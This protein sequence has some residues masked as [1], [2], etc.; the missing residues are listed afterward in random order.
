MSTRN[1]AERSVYNAWVAIPPRQHEPPLPRPRLRR[2]GR[3]EL[4]RMARALRAN[5]PL[6]A[7]FVLAGLLVAFSS[8]SAVVFTGAAGSA[9]FK[10][11][12]GT[13][14]PLGAGLE[15]LRRGSGHEPKATFTL[16]TH[17]TRT[18]A[19]A[20]AVGDSSSLGPVVSTLS[21][22][23]V[24][25]AR[26]AKSIEIVLMARTGATRHIRRLAGSG[27]GIWLADSVASYLGVGPGDT[28]AVHG[29]LADAPRPPRRV[30]VGAIYRALWKSEANDYWAN[31]SHEIYPPRKG[32]PDM[33]PTFAFLPAEQLV[34]LHTAIGGHT[35]DERWEVPVR[36][37]AMTLGRARSLVDRFGRIGEQLASPRS[38]LS[39]SLG[40]DLGPFSGVS[41]STTSSLR[42][43]VG[44]ADRN[45]SAVAGSSALLGGIGTVVALA[46]AAA[47][48]FFLVARRRGEM[49]YR[50]TRGEQTSVFALRTALE[51]LPAILLGGVAGFVAV[52]AVVR[53]FEPHASFD[54]ANL[55]SAALVAAAALLLAGALL[56]SAACVAFLRQFR[57][58]RRSRSLWRRAP[59]ELVPALA[60][61][62]LLVTLH[63]SRS[64]DRPTSVAAFALPLLL[65]AGLGGVLLRLARLVVARARPRALP[66]SLAVRR[67]ASGSSLAALLTVV[68]A[69]ASGVLFYG[70]AVR[71]SLAEGTRAKGLVAIGGDVQGTIGGDSRL[72]PLPFPSTKVTVAYGGITLGSATGDQA[73]LMLVEPGRLAGV[74]HWNTAWGAS[75]RQLLPRLD[76]PDGDGLAVI[77]A[78]TSAGKPLGDAWISGDRV[79]LRVVG[80]VRAFPSMSTDRPLLIASADAFDRLGPAA[81]ELST[82][83]FTYV[84]A[85]GDER[86][87]ERALAA[88]PIGADYLLTRHD[89]LGAR[90]VVAAK[91][92]YGF[93]LLLGAASGVLALVGLLLYLSARQRSQTLASALLRRMG[94][95]PAAELASLACEV[96]AILAL[97][98]LVGAVV[99]L[100]TVRLVI[101]SLDP[102]PQY[103]PAPDP[104][105]PWLALAVTPALVVV[106][107]LVA[108]GLVQRGSRRANVVEELRAG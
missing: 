74:V 95:R 79:P 67:V 44:L 80:R 62:V 42:A 25:A 2:V 32:D 59:W 108:A 26:G 30:R 3:L 36:P 4:V 18:A 90:E 101:G 35:F 57:L 16:A 10:D 52:I 60:G 24:E 84:W 100:A 43:A 83:G 87:V 72:P 8:A 17:R 65:L 14:T 31:F 64:G 97:A 20:R 98:A 103:A 53:A 96:A 41:C 50:F 49:R 46:V 55:R 23:T 86:Q 82:T 6:V 13:M 7:A 69:V 78:G 77:V 81:A 106:V 75:P 107:A 56:V 15:V 76:Q 33:L 104:A 92:S 1:A 9:A 63:A 73:D 21:S 51:S 34:P 48:G 58:P 37:E 45:A 54:A 71:A 89:I 105:M 27:D 38:S 88:P 61:I 22:S 91:R 99:A 40:C 68:V 29:G 12:V 28:I 66:L 85:R 47:G 93:L 11:Q 5:R 19:F 39:K 70:L 102:L 94:L